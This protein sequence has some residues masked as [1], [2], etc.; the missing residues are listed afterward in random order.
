ME[1]FVR[2]ETLEIRYEGLEVKKI[3]K[4]S[5]LQ[6]PYTETQLL[7]KNCKED[8]TD[9]VQLSGYKHCPNCG[10]DLVGN[11]VAMYHRELK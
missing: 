4:H 6:G 10:H 8:V 7:C 1:T 11:R 3:T 9:L 2:E 5:Q